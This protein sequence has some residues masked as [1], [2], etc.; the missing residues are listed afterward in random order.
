MTLKSS[1]SPSLHSGGAGEGVDAAAAVA[2]VQPVVARLAPARAPRVL[3]DP[4]R[5]LLL[6]H[7]IVVL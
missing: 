4:E 7:R 1:V 2:P 6:K 5:H 3:D